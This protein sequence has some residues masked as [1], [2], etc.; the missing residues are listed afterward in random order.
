MGWHIT[1]AGVSV[2]AMLYML[3]QAMHPFIEQLQHL[4]LTIGPL[5]Q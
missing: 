4:H 3:A 1:A 2:S 5:V